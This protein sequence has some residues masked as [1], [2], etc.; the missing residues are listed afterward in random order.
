M[1]IKASLTDVGQESVKC[2]SQEGH[3]GQESDKHVSWV[4]HVERMAHTP[5][6]PW[7]DKRPLLRMAVRETETL[8]DSPALRDCNCIILRIQCPIT[9]F[10]LI[11]NCSL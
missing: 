6:P 8:S 3:V 5:E 9:K 11:C 1:S 2:V 7:S 4:D 10:E